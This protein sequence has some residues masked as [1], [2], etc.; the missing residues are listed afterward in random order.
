MKFTSILILFGLLVSC[1]EKV[2]APTSVIPKRR[3]FP[4]NEKINPCDDYYEYACSNAIAGFKLRDDRSRHSFSFSDSY[5]RILAE[6]KMYLNKLLTANKFNTHSKQLHDN[7]AACMDVKSR[8]VEEKTLFELALKEMREVTTKEQFSKM[9]MS[10]SLLGKDGLI[11][12]FNN[13]NLDDNNV[14]DL[15]IL[16]NKLASLPEVSYYQKKDLMDEYKKV[17]TDFFLLTKFETP[18]ERA[19]SVIKFEIA[20]MNKYPK[21]AQR[22]LIWSQRNYTTKKKLLKFKSLSLNPLLDKVPSHIK[23]RNPMGGALS[24]LNK[25]IM[26]TSLSTLKDVYLYQAYSGI[27]DQ[28]YPKFYKKKF[29][30]SHKFLGGSPKRGE[31]DERC[32]RK[33][34]R[35]FGKEIDAELFDT[36]FPNFPEAKF[37]KTLERVRTSIVDGLSENKWLSEMAKKNAIKKIKTAKF[38]V[39]KPKTENEWNFNPIATYSTKTYLG[40]N[41]K[42]RENLTNRQFDRLAKPKDKKIWFMGPLTVNAYYDSS[43]NQFVMPAGILQYPFF[44][45]TGEEWTNLGAIGA[46]VGHELGHGVDDQGS[47]YDENGRLRQWMTNADLENFKSR[48]AKLVKQFNEAGHDGKLTL[49]ENIGDLVGVTFALAAAQKVMPKDQIDKATKEFFLQYARAWCSVT[50]PKMKERLLKT[51]PHSLGIA[52][53]NEQMKHQSEFARVYQ[54]KSSNKLVIPE[55]ERVKIW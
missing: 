40:N 51:D 25:M 32:A 21:P 47:K 6:K 37:L 10:K 11:N 12:H 34:M 29:D 52:R 13:T 53:V 18:G 31:L 33:V 14:F 28:A 7:Y 39:V 46:V 55:E 22:R 50:R 19:D 49:G 30:F 8:A 45:T 41:Q 9:L 44:D 16:P 15:M 24:N 5:E 43:N 20:F 26:M 2:G 35:S 23:I 38:Q 27:L 54:C 36:F 1:S 3:E 17:V 48:G 42:L 4:I